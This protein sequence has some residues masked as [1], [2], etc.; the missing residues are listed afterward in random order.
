MTTTSNLRSES[1]A[2]GR[3]KGV[4]VRAHLQFVRDRLGEQALEA[5]M[6]ALPA[7]VAAEVDGILASTWCAFGSLVAL[8]RT[9]ARVA[10]REERELMHDLGRYSA[11]INLSTVYRAFHRDDIHEFFRN[12]AML[13]R[14]FQDF[15]DCVYERVGT[16]HGRISVC[17]AV[18]YSPAYCSSEAGYLEQVIATH[19]GTAAKVSESACQCAGD[20]RCTFE[21]RWL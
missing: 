17:N 8:D 7:P 18:C 9:I 4:M 3:V 10:G 20:D 1:L 14:Q 2:G 21:L 12:S 11:Q 13:H 16:M 19:G 5:T 6:S 15:G